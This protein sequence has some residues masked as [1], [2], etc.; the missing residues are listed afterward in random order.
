MLASMEMCLRGFYSSRSEE[1]FFRDRKPPV[2]LSLSSPSKRGLERSQSAC[3]R[4]FHKPQMRVV[5]RESGHEGLW[6][7]ESAR[8]PFA[9]Q[10]RRR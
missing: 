3:Q 9:D 10:C 7:G 8:E 5:V 6:P 4:N 1:A 2:K